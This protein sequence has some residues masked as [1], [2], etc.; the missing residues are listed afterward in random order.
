MK[1]L[2]KKNLFVLKAAINGFCQEARNIRV[3]II[4]PNHSEKKSWGWNRKRLLGLHTRFHLLA[5]AFML[6][7]RYDELEK[8]KPLGVNSW[9][10]GPAA[11]EIIS[12]CR[13][14]GGYRVRYASKE[15][16]QE[17]ILR[18]FKTGENLV[19]TQEK[20]EI[21]DIDNNIA[22]NMY[23]KVTTC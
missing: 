13:M 1:A 4:Q 8:N 20:S 9:Q 10:S 11:H 23:Q 6:G 5:Y 3:K 12:I 2:K 7:K 15:L 17:A 22:N 19:F 18:W 14:Y 21:L 16:S